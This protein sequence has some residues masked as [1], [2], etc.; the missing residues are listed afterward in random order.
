MKM[1]T[2]PKWYAEKAELENG[3]DVSAGLPPYIPAFVPSEADIHYNGAIAKLLRTIEASGREIIELQEELSEA[4]SKIARLRG[5]IE[6]ALRCLDGDPEYH[7][8]GMGCGLEDRGITD[9]YDA[10]AYGWEQAMERVYGENIAWAKDSLRTAVK[11]SS[12]G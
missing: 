1:P 6:E 9:R 5:S 2:D 12:D 3:C 8:Q 7:I 10:M 4:N 11:E